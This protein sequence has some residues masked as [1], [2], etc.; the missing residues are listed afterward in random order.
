MQRGGPRRGARLGPRQLSALRPEGWLGLRQV[1]EHV[2]ANELQSGWGAEAWIEFDEAMARVF[3]YEPP[4]AAAA[5]GGG[6]KKKKGKARPRR[7]L[8]VVA[9]SA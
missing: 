5:E 1:W 4:A 3:K 9:R 8:V 7:G 6:K 2:K